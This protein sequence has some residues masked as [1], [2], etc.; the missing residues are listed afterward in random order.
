MEAEIFVTACFIPDVV[1]KIV[2][3]WIEVIQRRK[4]KS[5]G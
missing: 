4:Q 1:G 2:A 3:A 5:R